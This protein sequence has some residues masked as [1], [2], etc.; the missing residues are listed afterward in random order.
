MNYWFIWL[1]FVP[2]GVF[3]FGRSFHDSYGAYMPIKVILD[4]FGLINAFGWLGYNATWWF[5]SCIILLYASF[6]FLYWSYK[7]DVLLTTLLV[8]VVCF[9]PTPIFAGGKLYFGAFYMGM[10]YCDYCKVTQLP[11]P[12]TCL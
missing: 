11:P 5:Y 8:A 10:I 3:M 4:F 2:I 7:K 6:P 12:H 1:V 9:F